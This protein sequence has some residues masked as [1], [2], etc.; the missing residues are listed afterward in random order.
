MV[1]LMG[2]TF[3][4]VAFWN[5]PILMTQNIF[6]GSGSVSVVITDVNFTRVIYNGDI[7]YHFNGTDGTRNRGV[8]LNNTRLSRDEVIT[9]DN[10]VLQ[11]TVDYSINHLATNSTLELYNPL[12]DDQTVIVDYFTI[13]ALNFTLNT[14]NVWGLSLGGTDGNRYRTYTLSGSTMGEYVVV[15][16]FAL[17]EIIDYNISRSP[18]QSNITFL[19]AIWDDQRVTFRWYQ[20]ISP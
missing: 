7:S 19:N 5:T 6:G 10:Y 20:V 17:M 8:G 9:I 11:S 14:T 16:N 12:W 18:A 2:G 15:D 1:L 13:G 3:L 4:A